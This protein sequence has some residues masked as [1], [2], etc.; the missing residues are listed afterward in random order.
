MSMSESV[1]MGQDDFADP[2][3]H[4]R[5]PQAVFRKDDSDVGDAAP[6]HTFRLLELLK[7]EIL[8]ASVDPRYQ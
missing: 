3:C 2:S 6:A 5:S 1:Y 7:V 4:A 8:I